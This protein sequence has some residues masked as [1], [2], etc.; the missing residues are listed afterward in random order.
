[1]ARFNNV[2]V[3]AFV[4]AGVLLASGSMPASA[5]RA[6]TTVG[7]S[8]VPNNVLLPMLNQGSVWSGRILYTRPATAQGEYALWSIDADGRNDQQVL[9]FPTECGIGNV[10][11]APDG[12][13][14][15][16]SAS[17]GD[18]SRQLRLVA[19][20]GSGDRLLL[21]DPQLAQYTFSPDGSQLAFT[22][23]RVGDVSFGEASL[24]LVDTAG[25]T[26]RE[27]APW[28]GRPMYP[29]WQDNEH[30]LY[31]N[32]SGSIVRATVN[33]NTPPQQVLEKGTVLAL[34]PDRTTVLVALQPLP[35]TDVPPRNVPYGIGR[36]EGTQFRLL[37]QWQDDE[38]LASFA[39]SPTS[40]QLAQLNGFN[41]YLA[42]VQADGTRT[43]IKSFPDSEAPT[44]APGWTADGRDVIYMQLIGDIRQTTTVE[45]RRVSVANGTEQTLVTFEGNGADFVVIP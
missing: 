45:L 3:I 9:V 41:N 38:Y 34:A 29:A 11:V 32:T 7:Q 1:M 24:W 39:W 44:D 6:S 21:N 30:L 15:A 16:Y 35:Y 10:V 23:A 37:H 14:I 31:T 5:A 42:V 22:K 12:S 28:Q 20:D 2:V 19:P 4:L 8:N 26:P 13:Q 36:I 43:V 33:G 25:G 27:L 40:T 17:C 18:G